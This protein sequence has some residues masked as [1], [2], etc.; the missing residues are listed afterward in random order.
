MYKYD[1]MGMY[2]NEEVSKKFIHRIE[3][4]EECGKTKKHHN[5]GARDAWSVH[6]DA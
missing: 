2:E 4:Q 5:I 6:G 1:K 3:T